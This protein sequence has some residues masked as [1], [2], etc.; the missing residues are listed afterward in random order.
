VKYTKKLPTLTYEIIVE[1]TIKSKSLSLG[2]DANLKLSIL[3]GLVKVDGA[4]NFL[5]DKR[6]SEK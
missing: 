2:I 6:S 4:A 1:D 3:S 5:E